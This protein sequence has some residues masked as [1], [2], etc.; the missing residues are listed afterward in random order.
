MD[1]CIL[2]LFSYLL[3]YKVRHIQQ[4]YQRHHML[5]VFNY[6]VHALLCV[7]VRVGEHAHCSQLLCAYYWLHLQ[8]NYYG[9]NTLYFA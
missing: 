2:M 9:H 1:W 7:D 4:C 3:N 8:A 5:H 6:D